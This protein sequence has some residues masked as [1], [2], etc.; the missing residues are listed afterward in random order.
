METQPFQGNKLRTF[1]IN[2]ITVS[3]LFSLIFENFQKQCFA[4]LNFDLTIY[5]FLEM[6]HT[7][8]LHNNF[9]M[10]FLISVHC[11]DSKCPDQ[12]VAEGFTSDDSGLYIKQNKTGKFEDSSKGSN[13][14]RPV[15]RHESL[16]HRCIWWHK[17]YRHWW[18]GNCIR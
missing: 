5:N 10:E 18:L 9:Q 16:T 11:V 2:P 13:L 8:F 4:I 3:P 15:Y 7:H 12:V 14:E 17:P 1:K 6:N